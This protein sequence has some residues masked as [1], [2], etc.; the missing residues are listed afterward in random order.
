MFDNEYI[1]SLKRFISSVEIVSRKNKLQVYD[2]V[3]LI[4]IL[5]KREDDFFISL[6]ERGVVLEYCKIRNKELAQLYF[7]IFVKRGVTDFEFP[8][9]TL[10]NDI[11]DIEILKEYLTREQLDDFYSVDFRT[12]GKINF[13]TKLNK[14][15]YIDASDNEYN[16]FYLPNRIFQ[17][18][19][20]S[21]VKLKTIKEWMI[22]LNGDNGLV[23][24]YEATLLGYSSEGL[25]RSDLF[26]T[27]EK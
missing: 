10:I 22:Q 16:L 23:D 5:E 4:Y 15:Y 14:I 6:N 20:V 21:I 27:K 24:E 25:S 19:Y 2:N 17:T 11:E 13:S 7:A 1:S 3:D 8:L 18:F 9:M 26:V 12:K